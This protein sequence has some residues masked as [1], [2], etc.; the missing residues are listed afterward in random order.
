VHTS[1]LRAA[2][3]PSR[4][5]NLM[6]KSKTAPAIKKIADF[7][8]I[9]PHLASPPIPLPSSPSRPSESKRY[10]TF[11]ISLLLWEAFNYLTYS[12][13]VLLILVQQFKKLQKISS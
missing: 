9:E 6:L 10:L 1:L 5:L 3:L 11:F 12:K 7:G 2:A 8:G 13:L 4:S